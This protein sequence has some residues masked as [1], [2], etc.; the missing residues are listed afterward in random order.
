MWS[1]FVCTSLCL[2]M[3]VRVCSAHSFVWLVTT[4]LLIQNTF[5]YT[6]V[7]VCGEIVDNAGEQI[8]TQWVMKTDG[9]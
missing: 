5:C 6:L 3:T 9:I 7:S 1:F 2:N 4:G 8:Q